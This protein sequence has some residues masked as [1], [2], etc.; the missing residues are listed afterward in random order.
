MKIEITKGKDMKAEILT[1]LNEIIHRE[2]TVTSSESVLPG[3]IKNFSDNTFFVLYNREK[4]LSLG[5][6]RP[7]SISFKR[8]KYPI[9]G[10]AD[11]I[12]V[13]K[14]KGYGKK[15]MKAMIAHLDKN[16]QIGIGFCKR[17]NGLFYKKCGYLI[18][19]DL[20]GRFVY[21]NESGEI[22]GDRWDDDVLYTKYGISLIN[23]ILRNSEENVWIPWKHW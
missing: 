4:I 15:L 1:K 20:V 16:K 12:S 7:V 9:Q 3:N 8:K 14:E 11:V 6:L 23:K 2:F 13:E 18:V 19:E 21:K 5:R 17:S 10:I 22:T